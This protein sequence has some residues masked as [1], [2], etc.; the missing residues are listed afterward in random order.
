MGGMTKRQP[1]FGYNL[2]CGAGKAKSFWRW[3]VHNLST[4]I[5]CDAGFLYGTKEEAV[6]MATNA[7]ARLSS[8]AHQHPMNR[9][10]APDAWRGPDRVV[11]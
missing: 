7:I 11:R 4:K 5:I 1:K 10:R 6:T 8:P 2:Y 3:E 9:N